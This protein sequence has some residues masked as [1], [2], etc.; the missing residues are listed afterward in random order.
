[1]LRTVG[2]MAALFSCALGCSA[3]PSPSLS[4][5]Q[6]G[7]PARA[8]VRLVKGHV[9]VASSGGVVA[10]TAMKHASADVVVAHGTATAKFHIDRAGRATLVGTRLSRQGVR[11]LV[12]DAIDAFGLATPGQTAA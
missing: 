10:R 12:A 6:R 8:T 5:A 7:A 4:S 1:M 11:R 2:V 3:S 9:L